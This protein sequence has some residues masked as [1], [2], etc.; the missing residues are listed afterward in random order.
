MMSMFNELQNTDRLTTGH[1][2]EKDFWSTQCMTCTS[3]LLQKQLYG[4]NQIVKFVKLKCSL[5]FP[6]LQ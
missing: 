6:G 4:L 2:N 5:N 1:F 3:S